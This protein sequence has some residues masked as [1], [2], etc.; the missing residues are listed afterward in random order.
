MTNKIT[1][2]ISDLFPGSRRMYLPMENALMTWWMG[3]GKVPSVSSGDGDQ[4]MFVCTATSSSLMQL[5][6][7]LLAEFLPESIVNNTEA[8]ENGL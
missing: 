4:G 5:P 1:H 3:L 6:S 7:I 8:S 2:Q